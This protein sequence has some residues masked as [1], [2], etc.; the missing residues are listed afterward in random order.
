MSAKTMHW[1][2]RTLLCRV[3][4]LGDLTINAETDRHQVE[5]AGGID[6]DLGRNLSLSLQAQTALSKD[7]ANY[8]GHARVKWRF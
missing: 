5:L 6:L 3:A 1:Y 8:G 7:A 4:S 2:E